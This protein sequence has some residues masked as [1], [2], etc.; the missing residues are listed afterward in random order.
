MR[1]A[2]KE[3]KRKEQPPS[4]HSHVLSL[5]LSLSPLGAVVSSSPTSKRHTAVAVGSENKKGKRN[6][7]E[8]RDERNNSSL[9]DDHDGNT[10]HRLEEEKEERMRGGEKKKN[11]KY[12][13]K[14]PAETV[15]NHLLL[16]TFP[17]CFFA[18]KEERR[19]GGGVQEGLGG[20]VL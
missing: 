18:G 4:R 10:T 6:G 14:G 2:K 20:A 8:E 9:P 5:S 15:E 11:A 1:N 3:G 12:N 19:N 7:G 17:F 13:D 16:V